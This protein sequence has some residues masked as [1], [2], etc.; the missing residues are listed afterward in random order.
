MLVKEVI[1]HLSTFDA[2]D[3]ILV[4]FWTK[5]FAPQ[6]TP[7][8]WHKALVMASQNWGGVIEA[9]SQLLNN[10]IKEAEAIAKAEAEQDSV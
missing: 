1:K 4:F 8:Q 9:G 6:L 7:E 3:D 10:S 5:D 2:E